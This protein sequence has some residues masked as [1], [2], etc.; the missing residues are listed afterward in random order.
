LGHLDPRR[1]ARRLPDPARRG[2]PAG[3]GL[4]RGRAP[5]A[6]APGKLP[7]FRFLTR[8]LHQAASGVAWED[9]GVISDR[10]GAVGMRIIDLAAP[11]RSTPP[12]TPSFSRIEIERTSHAEGAAQV[13]TMLHV[14]AALLRDGEGWAVE[15]FTKLGTHGV[16]HVDAPWH[17]NSM[18]QGRRSA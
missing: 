1:Q 7:V 3:G 9:P 11:I 13:E 6:A 4:R 15:E 17:Y 16:T 8:G 2:A 10:E 18:I 12:G 14:P 5:R